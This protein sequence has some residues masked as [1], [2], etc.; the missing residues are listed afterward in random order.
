MYILQICHANELIHDGWITVDEFHDDVESHLASPSFEVCAG[1]LAR[2]LKDDSVFYSC[3]FKEDRWM[4]VGTDHPF[5]NKFGWDSIFDA[6]TRSLKG[7]TLINY[8][9]L[10]SIPRIYLIRAAFQ[11]V[12]IPL[13]SLP[14]RYKNPR[15]A[16]KIISRWLNGESLDDDLKNVI[17]KDLSESIESSLSRRNQAL[18]RSVK[19]L[20]QGIDRPERATSAVIDAT[21]GYAC[22]DGLSTSDLVAQG[23]INEKF[24]TIVRETIP[25][26]EVV[27]G[28]LC[29]VSSK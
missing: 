14:T 11:C 16:L 18:I 17:L 4:S 21:Y 1:L 15:Y 23:T 20:M 2:V 8:C 10:L 28:L 9:A 19:Y 5:A 3:I 22:K 12:S 7:T 29:H 6:W 25:F 27:S 24:A 26:S 13:E